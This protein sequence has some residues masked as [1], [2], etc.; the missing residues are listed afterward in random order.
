[1]QPFSLILGAMGIV[2]G[3]VA[4]FIFPGNTRYFAAVILA[5]LPIG[6]A[7]A[8]EKKMGGA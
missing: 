6:A 4:L 3:G 5:G 1:M 7:A 2:M 8:M